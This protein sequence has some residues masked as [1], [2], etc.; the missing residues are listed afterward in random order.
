MIAVNRLMAGRFRSV[1]KRCVVGRPRGPAPPV[2]VE[3]SADEVTLFTNLGNVALALRL[4]EQMGQPQRIV[5]PAS[6][7]DEIQNGSGGDARIDI[8]A[9]GDGRCEWDQRGERRESKWQSLGLPEGF[10]P[11]P[12]PKAVKPVDASLLSALHECGKCTS[13]ESIRFAMSRL[14]IQGKAGKVAGTDGRQLLV[15]NGFR[16]AFPESILVPA[17]PVFASREL[18]TETDVRLGRTEQRLVMMIGPWTVW[19]TIDLEGRFPDVASVIPQKLQSELQIDAS[20]APG[21]V[22][23]LKDALPSDDDPARVTLAFG[24]YPAIRVHTSASVP[25]KDLRLPASRCSGPALHVSLNPDYLDRALTLGLLTV[26]TPSVTGPVVFR[27]ERRTYVTTCF[28]SSTVATTAIAPPAVDPLPRTQEGVPPMPTE[29]DG[30]SRDESPCESADFMSEAEGL[31]DSL[32]D[33]A[34]RA[35]RLVGMLRQLQKQRR[36]LET[37]WSSLKNLRLG[38]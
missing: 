34:R 3:R 25:A 19:L 21:L 1:A 32:G 38:P 23:A 15:W 20:D 8:D 18:T 31:R 37:A 12:L 28:A 9:N 11:W 5:V 7:L 22:H 4:S 16:F 33:V 36:V 17:V 13:R 27:D 24:D 6:L 30:R 2:V 10:G 35:A 14:Q 26:Q 29:S